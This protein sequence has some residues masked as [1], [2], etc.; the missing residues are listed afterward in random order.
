MIHDAAI[1]ALRLAKRKHTPEAALQALTDAGWLLVPTAVVESST[2]DWARFDGAVD[3]VFA[4]QD[5]T[6]DM[7]LYDDMPAVDAYRLGAATVTA[8]LHAMNGDGRG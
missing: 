8:A 2:N 3:A 5:G 6:V 4:N 1:E 7:G